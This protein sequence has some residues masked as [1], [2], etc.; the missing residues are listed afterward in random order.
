[1]WAC[2]KPHYY[3]RPF[4]PECFSRDLEWVK[5]SGR[6]KIYSYVV[7]HHP[8]PDFQDEASHV[9]AVIELGKGPRMMSNMTGIEP[10]STKVQVDMPVEIVFEDVSD[11]LTIFKFRP[12]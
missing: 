9:I 6:G 3:P 1:M 8:G 7:N 10:D 2:G 11:Q 12:G 5:C 4:C